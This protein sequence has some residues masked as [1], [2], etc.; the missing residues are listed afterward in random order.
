MS[1]SLIQPLVERIK[2]QLIAIDATKEDKE[3]CLNW[4]VHEYKNYM[5]ITSEAYKET[6]DKYIVEFPDSIL[7]KFLFVILE[8]LGKYGAN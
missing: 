2:S 3:N 1:N 4:M 8:N 7:N 6:I 5:V